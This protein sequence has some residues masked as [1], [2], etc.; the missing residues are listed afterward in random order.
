MP[1]EFTIFFIVISDKSTSEAR[2]LKISRLSSRLRRE[3]HQLRRTLRVHRYRHP[4]MVST[5][6]A[7]L[8]AAQ[9]DAPASVDSVIETS[10]MRYQENHSSKN[11]HITIT[12]SYQKFK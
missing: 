7:L 6:V 8:K 12:F 1:N 2:T 4:T 3:L 10:K 11:E 5:A 9:Q